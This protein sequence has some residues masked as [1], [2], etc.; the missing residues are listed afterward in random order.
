MGDSPLSFL[1]QTILANKA[2]TE[3]T[4]SSPTTRQPT[5]AELE[6]LLHGG[7]IDL[8]KP[9]VEPSEPTNLPANSSVSNLPKGGF[10]AAIYPACHAVVAMAYWQGLPYLALSDLEALTFP[11]ALG[12]IKA[13]GVGWR[14][15]TG[16]APSAQE[17]I[18]FTSKQF[19]NRANLL[20]ADK[21]W[22]VT[23][24]TDLV[25]LGVPISK[26][27]ALSRSKAEEA[28]TAWKAACLTFCAANGIRDPRAY[29]DG[30]AS[31]H[32]KPSDLFDPNDLSA[33]DDL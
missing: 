22:H 7:E 8:T 4:S 28:F 31:T 33:F 19:R 18:A 3:A 6:I 9:P 2:K 27:Q 5:P 13:K 10:R 16:M 17:S 24:M 26:A 25:R 1:Q 14:P 15:L 12:Y 21:G 11:N 32:S 29:L 30:H 23:I 20:F